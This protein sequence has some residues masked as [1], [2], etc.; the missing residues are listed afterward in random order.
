MSFVQV[1]GLTQAVG[2]DRQSFADHLRHTA[3]QL[4]SEGNGFVEDIVIEQEFDDETIWTSTV[5][6]RR[7]LSALP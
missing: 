7:P 4:R 3:R 2:A 5:A 1:Y 6:I